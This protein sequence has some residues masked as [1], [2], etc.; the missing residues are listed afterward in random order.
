MNISNI[1]LIKEN[2]KNELKIRQINQML[3]IMIFIILM[4]SIKGN[5]KFN[6]QKKYNFNE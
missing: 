1:L 3:I 4:K 5:V 6:F 2:Q